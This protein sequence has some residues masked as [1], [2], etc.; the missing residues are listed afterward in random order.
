MDGFVLRRRAQNSDMSRQR[1]SLASSRNVPERFFDR[2]L[3]AGAPAR[4]AASFGRAKPYPNNWAIGFGRR[5]VNELT[6]RT[7]KY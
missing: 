5:R 6:A 7:S 1:P 3:K 2:P 4:P